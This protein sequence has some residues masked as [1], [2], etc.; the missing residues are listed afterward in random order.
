VE[1]GWH[2]VAIVSSLVADPVVALV[3]EGCQ[4]YT[5]IPLASH[6]PY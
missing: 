5:A 4:R 2:R 6:T 1:V 3:V